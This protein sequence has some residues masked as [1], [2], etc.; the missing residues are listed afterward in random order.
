MNFALNVAETQ[1]SAWSDRDDILYVIDA[2]E[3]AVDLS[4]KVAL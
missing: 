4:K 2:L 3:V 1:E